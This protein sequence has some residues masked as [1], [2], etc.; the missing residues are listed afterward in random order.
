MK[1]IVSL[2]FAGSLVFGSANAQILN[3][4]NVTLNMDIQP[5]LQLML[6]GPTQH[7]FVFDD[8]KDY[9]AGIVKYGAN[10]LKVS[11]SV[12]FDLW[13]AGLSQQANNVWDPIYDYAGGAGATGATNVMPL[14]ALE[15]RQ[16]PPN[17]M[18]ADA[19]ASGNALCGLAGNVAPNAQADYSSAFVTMDNNNTPTATGSN[20]IYTPGNANPY[21]P[22]NEHTPLSEEKYIAGAE[23]T[24][25]DCGVPPGSYLQQ[26]STVSSGTNDG[27]Y[28][29]MDYRL[30]P[31]L[32]AIFPMH[33]VAS[34]TN[35]GETGITNTAGITQAAGLTA[36][37]GGYVAPGVYSMYIKYII[38]EDQ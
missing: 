24:A 15:L 29:V 10:I 6:E 19:V 35:N 30:I 18:I 2:I 20:V 14:T 8:I 26:G 17:P 38:T 34:N 3:E 32:P 23:G 5:V 9:Y 25:T 7:E 37:L 36:A 33:L 22:P 12:K 16:F 21:A 11:A 31:G 4:Q 28:F 27:Y 13:A 1:K